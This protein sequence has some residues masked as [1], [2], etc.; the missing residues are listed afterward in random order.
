MDTKKMQ[1]TLYVSDL[2]GTLLHSDEK[3][4]EYAARKLNELA[5]GGMLFS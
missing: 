3:I 4:S 5:Q 2:D 1:R